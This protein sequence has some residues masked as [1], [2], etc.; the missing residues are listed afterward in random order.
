MPAPARP[1]RCRFAP[2][3]SGPAHP[4][5]LLAALL[6]WLDARSRGAELI[7]RL[8]DIDPERCTPAHADAICA[9]LEWLGIDWDERVVQST[10]AAA[11]TGALRRLAADG[12][13]YACTCTR[14]E[15]RRARL[16]AV[17]GGWRYP[18]TCRARGIGADELDDC[19]AALR[20]RLP[21]GEIEARDESG[22][23]LERDP[24][25]ALGDPLL[26]RRDGT[27]SY[28]LAVVVDDAIDGIT[29]IVRGRDLAHT[30]AGQIALQ[31]L[32]D[33]PTPAYRHHLLLLEPRGG[34]LA[35]LHGSVAWEQ[36]RE[37]YGPAELCG[38]LASAAG[39]QRAPDPIRP[40]G[41]LSGFG[42]DQVRRTDAR[43][44]WSDG[45]LELG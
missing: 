7:L 25:R 37:V 39:L 32:L 9:A 5:T 26:R 44:R 17:D 16:P 12:R 36:L 15:I 29:R 42:W 3:T 24:L 40:A 10:R 33:L 2:T 4:G 43:V 14:A 31:R 11:H 1:E 28:A 38:W 45:R 13:L 20:L 35:K 27:V 23:D 18:G 8:E 41:L 30:T 34:K 21:D 6:C 19:D 22:L